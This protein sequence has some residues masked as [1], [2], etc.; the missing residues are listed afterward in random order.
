[1]SSGPILFRQP[2][3]AVAVGFALW[4]AGIWCFRD[5]YQRRGRTPPL[6]VRLASPPWPP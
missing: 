6:P 4:A 5:A 1:M 3:A 2:K